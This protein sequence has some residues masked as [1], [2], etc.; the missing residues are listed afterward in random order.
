MTFY[1][2]IQGV[3]PLCMLARSSINLILQEEDQARHEADLM[4]TDVA[5][6]VT[7]TVHGYTYI[8]W[9]MGPGYCRRS[10][11]FREL[12]YSKAVIVLWIRARSGTGSFVVN[13]CVPD[14]RKLCV[15]SKLR[16]SLSTR[17]ISYESS[18]GLGDCA[19]CNY[20]QT[21]GRAMDF[22][23][24]PSGSTNKNSGYFLIRIG[25]QMQKYVC[26]DK[27]QNSRPGLA[28]LQ[29]KQLE[30]RVKAAMITMGKD[31]DP[32]LCCKL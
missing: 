4:A 1:T 3:T 17:L 11:R 16:K 12:F 19:V 23:P 24:C 29:D 25:G 28:R 32:D 7:K 20:F 18:D 8:F 14:V 10:G 15:E 21:V 2:L 31:T 26:I 6:G 27:V 5:K 22:I 13:L 30:Y 9:H